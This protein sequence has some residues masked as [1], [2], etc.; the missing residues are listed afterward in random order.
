MNIDT[1]MLAFNI[2]LIGA[3]IKGKTIIIFDWPAGSQYNGLS[4]SFLLTCVGIESV[5]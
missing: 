1:T 2:V 4:D 3:P 5:A